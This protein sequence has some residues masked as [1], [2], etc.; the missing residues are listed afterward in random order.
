MDAILD[1]D[2]LKNVDATDANHDGVYGKAHILSDG[3]VGRFGRKATDAELVK[4][5]AGAFQNEMGITNPMALLEP[6]LEF[7]SPYTT[8]DPLPEPELSLSDLQLA[9][10]FVRFLKLPSQLP[11]SGSANVGKAVFSDIGCATCHL[12]TFVTGPSS[13]KALN[14]KPAPLFSDLLLHDMGPGLADNCRGQ[15]NAADFR[16]EPL[17]GL[18]FRTR[19]MHDGLSNTVQDA[20]LR[21][22]GEGQGAR[23]RFTGLN[24]GQRSALLA[25]LAAL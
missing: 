13:V 18:R 4:F 21:H 20:I 15:A 7:Y 9:N 2:I 16:T 25:Y 1:A 23:D 19:F 10:D 5:N 3:R 17:A 8:E 22:A 6:Q 11:L 24:G 12:S 14:R